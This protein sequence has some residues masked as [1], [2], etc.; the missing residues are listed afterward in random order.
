MLSCL[1]LTCGDDMSLGWLL[2][3]CVAPAFLGAGG[4]RGVFVLGGVGEWCRV[5]RGVVRLVFG[6][7]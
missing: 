5:V 4:G 3:V 2:G 1:A 7:F 6:C